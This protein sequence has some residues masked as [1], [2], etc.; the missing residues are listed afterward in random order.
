MVAAPSLYLV[1]DGSLKL[2]EG[3]EEGRGCTP[4][5]PNSAPPGNMLS[6]N[7]VGNGLWAKYHC[8][9]LF[10]AKGA[11]GV[12]VE[13]TIWNAN[14]NHHTSEKDA[15]LAQKLGQL[16]PFIAALPQESMGQLASFGPT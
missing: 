5:N 8:N 14:K 16:Q 9:R 10:F 4:Q 2:G 15:K 1:I 7:T 13:W 3:T 11:A 6:A 12:W